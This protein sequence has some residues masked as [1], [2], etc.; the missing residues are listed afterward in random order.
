MHT[1]TAGHDIMTFEML[2]DGFH[3]QVRTSTSAPVEVRG[4][5]IGMLDCSR[6]VLMSVG[7][8]L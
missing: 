6:P 1:Q 7:L 2:R 5:G 8:L 3:N 4:N